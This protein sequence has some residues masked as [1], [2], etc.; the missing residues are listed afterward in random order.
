M[1]IPN[2]FNGYSK[3]GIRLYNDPITIAIV[4]ASAG[5]MLTPKDPLKGAMLGAAAG[6]GGGALLG[7]GAVGAGAAGAG[8]AGA[9]IAAAPLGSLAGAGSAAGTYAAAAPAAAPGLLSSLGGMA[10]GA[11]TFAQQNPMLTSLGIQ[12]A[13]SLLPQEQPPPQSAGLMRGQ[14]MQQEAPAYAMARPQLSLI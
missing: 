13:Q 12:T 2:K 4:G 5:A 1:R 10:S 11:G 9:G 6:F 8:A 3:D 14:Q 7:A